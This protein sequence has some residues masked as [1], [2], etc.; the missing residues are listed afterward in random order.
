[1]EDTE[2]GTRGGDGD[3]REEKGGT[4]NGTYGLYATHVCNNAH[5]IHMYINSHVCM[6]VCMTAEERRWQSG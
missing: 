5:C 4:T 2:G 6:Y 3:G 1:M